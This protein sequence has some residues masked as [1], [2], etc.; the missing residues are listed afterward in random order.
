MIGQLVRPATLGVGD[1]APKEY[2]EGALANFENGL[3]MG[4]G[5]LILRKSA[6]PLPSRM[7]V[8][9]RDCVT[10]RKKGNGGCEHREQSRCRKGEAMR[11]VIVLAL[12][13]IANV[14]LAA[15][16]MSQSAIKDECV[17][18]CKDAAKFINEKDSMRPSRR[19]ATRKASSL[20]KTRTYFSWTLKGTG[21]PIPM[22]GLKIR[23]L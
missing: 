19:L 17:A 2:E 22:R 11:K 13:V 23:R 16:V 15:S 7:E 1:I 21:L 14:V 8:I 9:G 5:F 3:R 12:V 6:S 18:L 20:R 4:V 10:L